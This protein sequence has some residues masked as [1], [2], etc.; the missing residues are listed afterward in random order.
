MLHVLILLIFTCRIFFS[1]LTWTYAAPDEFWQGPEIA[2][3]FVF[4][5]GFQT[6]E[7]MPNYALRSYLHPVL[8]ALFAYGPVAVLENVLS[9]IYAHS[10]WVSLH[11]ILPALWLTPRLLAAV[12]ASICDVATYSLALKLF[13]EDTAIL[14]LLVQLSST[15]MIFSSGRS[16]SNGLEATFTTCALLFWRKMIDRLVMGSAESEKAAL[17]P[18]SSAVYFASIAGALAGISFAIRPTSLI[19]WFFLWLLALP[20]IGLGRLFQIS[21][22]AITPAALSVILL[23]LLLDRYLYGFFTFPAFNF[24]LFNTVSGLDALYGEYPRLWYLYNGLPTAFGLFLPVA[25][26][27]IVCAFRYVKVS[28]LREFDFAI[29][30]AGVVLVLSFGSSHKEHRFLFPVLP[31]INIYLGRCLTFLSPEYVSKRIRGRIIAL[32]AAIHFIIGLYLNTFHQRGPVEVAKAIGRDAAFAHHSKGNHADDEIMQVHFL[33]PCHSTPFYSI[34]HYPVDLVQLDC[35]P[36][37][38][39][40]NL[41]GRFRT[42]ICEET[43]CCEETEM[44]LLSESDA[45]SRDPIAFL[46]AMYGSDAIT[47]VAFQPFIC[48]TDDQNTALQ[49]QRIKLD[50]ATSPTGFATQFGS[51]ACRSKLEINKKEMEFIHDERRL[52]SHMVLF[53]N[54]AEDKNIATWLRFHNYSLSASFHHSLV[55]GDLHSKNRRGS[56]PA[57]VHLYKHT[58]W[59][60][61]KDIQSTLDSPVEMIEGI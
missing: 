27:S 57:A 40:G 22:T 4:G 33:M 11:I 41:G 6:W 15:L 20:Q 59:N 36:E 21:F 26:F 29:A 17:I 60:Q 54:D 28:T 18:F 3:S 58:C 43:Q 19:I 53:D 42:Q 44:P 49:R 2:H 24:L 25:L 45:W 32:I 5:S 8:I 12:S 30:G 10:L 39:V 37:N 23:S 34:V 47:N 48:N 50:Y 1:V 56:D 16:F 13:G 52:P 46:G 55:K 61:W 51:K 14:A 38:R 9:H 31:I 35:S 7:W